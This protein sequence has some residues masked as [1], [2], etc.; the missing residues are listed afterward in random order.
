MPAHILSLKARDN[1]IHNGGF[2]ERECFNNGILI[3]EMS[4]SVK[5]SKISNNKDTNS[6]HCDVTGTHSHKKI[7]CVFCEMSTGDITLSD[8]LPI[9]F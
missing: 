3:K 1:L 6:N 2:E 5:Y 9:I 8:V 7:Q 4:E